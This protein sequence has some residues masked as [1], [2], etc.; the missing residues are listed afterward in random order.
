M[1]ITRR[2]RVVLI[3]NILYVL[4]FGV[5][6]VRELN[7]EFMLYTGVIVAMGAL[8]VW[9]QRTVRLEQPV[10]WG[11]TIW[12]MMHLA[13][14]NVQVGDGVLYNVELIR[15]IPKYNVLRYDQVVHAFG[16]GLAT[17]VFHHLL[18][19][20]LRTDIARSRTLL[21]L[22]VLMGSGIGAINE[23]VEFIATET[24]PKTNVGGYTN[25]MLDLVFNLLG[26]VGAACLI[27]VRQR[28]ESST[29]C[30]PRA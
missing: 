3:V 25:T 21:I 1:L 18:R 24:V 23:I 2:E 15:L 5:V 30:T 29:T 22:V 28:R 27:S 20:Y 4:G 8:I 7:I 19:P 14:G 13:G 10:L 6:M 16:F 26:G 12:G 9:K 17:L 11:L